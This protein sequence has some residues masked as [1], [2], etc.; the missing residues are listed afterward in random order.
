MQYLLIYKSGQYLMHV[1]V[2]QQGETE[3]SLQLQDSDCSPNA[4]VGWNWAPGWRHIHPL[5]V[6]QDVKDHEP[7]NVTIEKCA[8]KPSERME[9]VE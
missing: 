7:T 3:N 4:T 5:F 1:P 8:C 9:F 2:M 6:F